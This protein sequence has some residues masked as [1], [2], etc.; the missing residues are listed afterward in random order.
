MDR[1][2]GYFGMEEYRKALEDCNRVIGMREGGKGKKED[3]RR[4]AEVY[5]CLGEKKKA[6]QDRE[7]AN[8]LWD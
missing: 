3:Y 4:R 2:K 1:A 5:Q 8:N 6:D 7:M